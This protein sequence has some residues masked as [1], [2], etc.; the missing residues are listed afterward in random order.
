MLL[1]APGFDFSQEVVL[2][3]RVKRRTTRMLQQMPWFA[4][5]RSPVMV[6]VIETEL[7]RII[8]VRVSRIKVTRGSSDEP[9]FD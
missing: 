4:I 7:G 2:K 6:D 8:R 3:A 9:W 1:A 5:V